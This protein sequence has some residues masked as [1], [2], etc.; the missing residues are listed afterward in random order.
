MLLSWKL[1]LCF[2]C[3]PVCL[4][5][6]IQGRGAVHSSSFRADFYILLSRRIGFQGWVMCGE[7]HFKSKGNTFSK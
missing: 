1:K 6:E 4:F 7:D 2:L 5:F 3:F